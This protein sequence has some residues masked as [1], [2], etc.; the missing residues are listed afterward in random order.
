LRGYDA[1]FEEKLAQ[2]RLRDEEHM[3]W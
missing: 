1:L 3:H 2:L